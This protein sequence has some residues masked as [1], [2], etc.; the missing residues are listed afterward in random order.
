[1]LTSATCL[2]SVI[3]IFAIRGFHPIFAKKSGVISHFYLKYD[4][5]FVTIE[6]TIS[7]KIA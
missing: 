3:W 2:L 4:E 6:D 7:I 1:M 5:I